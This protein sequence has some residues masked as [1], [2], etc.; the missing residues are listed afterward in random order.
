MGITGEAFEGSPWNSK[1]TRFSSFSFSETK[2]HHRMS[3]S[4][5]GFGDLSRLIDRKK[6]Y[7]I[8]QKTSSSLANLFDGDS[9]AVLRSDD[10]PQML[11]VIPFTAQVRVRAVN[12]TG[13][14]NGTCQMIHFVT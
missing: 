3:D 10:D 7:C 11:I 14:Q 4:K 6:A 5:E 9:D 1:S 8:N 12:F 13:P 2:T